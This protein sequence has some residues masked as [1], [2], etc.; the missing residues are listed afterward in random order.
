MNPFSQ[1]ANF[2]RKTVNRKERQS[3]FKHLGGK[4]ISD[5]KH[6]VTLENGHVLRKLGLVFKK[7]QPCVLN[8][9]SSV[10]NTLVT[11][12]F[13]YFNDY[14]DIAEKKKRN[15]SLK[16]KDSYEAD[17][18]VSNKQSGSKSTKKMKTNDSNTKSFY[19]VK[20]DL[21]HC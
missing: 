11:I 14:I 6:T 10:P 18:T 13:N 20:S 4:R 21:S 8:K 9:L 12:D 1:G 16:R 17:P 3:Y 19:F 15:A 5:I 2:N 7:I